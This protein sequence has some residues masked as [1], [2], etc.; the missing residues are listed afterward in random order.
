MYVLDRPF[1]DSIATSYYLVFLQSLPFLQRIECTYRSLLAQSFKTGKVI[2]S[3][4][5]VK[6]ASRL[7]SECQAAGSKKKREKRGVQ[8][9]CELSANKA[10]WESRMQK[11]VDIIRSSCS[12]FTR[13]KGGWFGSPTEIDICVRRQISNAQRFEMPR[14]LSENMVKWNAM[15]TM[16]LWFT[17]PS[18]EWKSVFIFP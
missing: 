1:T 2:R 7:K 16:Y 6:L 12:Y 8:N 11:R 15:S 18:D 4:C 14:E 10:K 9:F 17:V 5:L 3:G 13:S